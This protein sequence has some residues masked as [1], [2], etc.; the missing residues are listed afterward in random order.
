MFGAY[1]YQRD[2]DLRTGQLSA[3]E[4]AAELLEETL[5]A[6]HVVELAELAY[7]NDPSP[8]TLVVMVSAIRQAG[9]VAEECRIRGRRA[10]LFVATELE[11]FVD[12]ASTVDARQLVGIGGELLSLDRLNAEQEAAERAAR[13]WE[14]VG[15]AAD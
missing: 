8:D 10:R 4:Y 1:T 11:G 7:Q 6:F 13:A 14:P 15:A 9:S 12:A 3:G 5:N 2:D